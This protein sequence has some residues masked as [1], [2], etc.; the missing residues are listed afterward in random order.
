[1]SFACTDCKA[2]YDKEKLAEAKIR[3]EKPYPARLSVSENKI[4]RMNRTGYM[5]GSWT[6]TVKNIT[7]YLNKSGAERPT[8]NGMDMWE[9][10]AKRSYYPKKKDRTD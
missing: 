6:D 1:M 5:K 4:R 2:P 3:N 10:Q 7:I 8:F 9:I